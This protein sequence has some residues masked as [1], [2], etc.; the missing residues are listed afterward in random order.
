[1]F[2]YCLVSFVLDEENTLICNAVGIAGVV[3][4]LALQI[5]LVIS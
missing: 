1:M 2:L 4:A 3:P 5:V